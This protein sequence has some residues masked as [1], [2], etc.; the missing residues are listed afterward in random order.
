MAH[1]YQLNA[2]RRGLAPRHPHPLS[3][4][5]LRLQPPL[6]QR[7]G[8]DRDHRARPGSCSRRAWSAWSR[9]WRQI[10]ARA[11]TTRSPG[12]S[13]STS[14]FLPGRCGCSPRPPMTA[15]ACS[16]PPS[17]SSPPSP[18]GEWWTM[19]D[20]LARLISA[21]V[22]SAIADLFS[23]R[24]SKRSAIADPTGD[25][26][27]RGLAR[28]IVSALVLGS[29]TWQLAR[30]HP[31][32]LSYYNELIGGPRG[33]LARPGSSC[34]TGTTPSTRETLEEINRILPRRR[35]RSP[36]STTSPTRRPRWGASRTSA[37]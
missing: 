8:P 2:D 9:P 6:A 17:S 31:F 35:P 4:R 27:A 15:S 16:S 3:G 21:P 19:G 11:A 14:I 20:G 34:R 7:L 30:V 37:S 12:T 26:R 33:R 13:P 28:G 1:Y 29:A 10:R 25:H 32:E 18:A 22:G 36:S 24:P 5:D 23:G